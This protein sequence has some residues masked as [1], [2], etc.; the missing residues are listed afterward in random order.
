MGDRFA[1]VPGG[2]KDSYRVLENLQLQ[3][4]GQTLDGARGQQPWVVSG[5]ITEFKGANYLLVTKASIQ[6]QEATAGA[7]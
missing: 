5:V 1:F 6:S 7:K 2:N 4:I 3:R